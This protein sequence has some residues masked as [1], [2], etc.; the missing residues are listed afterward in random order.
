LYRKSI[1][2][3]T[4]VGLRAEFVN[5]WRRISG[6]ISAALQILLFFEFLESFGPIVNFLAIVVPF[7]AVSSTAGL[8]F[9]VGCRCAYRNCA[10]LKVFVDCLLLFV[11]L[12]SIKDRINGNYRY[13]T[14]QAA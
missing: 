11:V 1:S 7:F 12:I 6:G 14:L 10:L 9:R 2:I 13:K 8:N 5:S 3:N 4:T